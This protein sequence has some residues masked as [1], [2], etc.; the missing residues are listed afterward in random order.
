M[1]LKLRWLMSVGDHAT[2]KFSLLSSGG[3]M[4]WNEAKTQE[5]LW[6]G[7]AMTVGRFA[8]GE[9]AKLRQELRISEAS[10]LNRLRGLPDGAELTDLFRRITELQSADAFYQGFFRG[11]EVQL[12]LQKQRRRGP[13]NKVKARIADLCVRHPDWSTKR[14]FGAL[15]DEDVPLLVIGSLDQK[16]KNRAKPKY[17]LDVVGDDAYKM[18]VSRIRDRMQVETRLK[19]WDKIIKQYAKLRRKNDSRSSSP[20]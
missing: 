14:I 15:D 17:W 8:P 20:S 16:T 9:S 4:G 5:M 18:L 2:R 12:G 11:Y 13:E 1:L 7:W 3:V 6:A 19:G 10:L